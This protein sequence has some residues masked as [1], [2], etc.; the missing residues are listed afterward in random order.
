MTDWQADNLDDE[1][2]AQG[3]TSGNPTL[4]RYDRGGDIGG[5]IVRDKLWFYTSAR[6]RR[7]IQNVLE[8]FRPDGE[9]CDDYE[10]GKFMWTYCR[11]APS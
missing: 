5:K 10:R 6:M 9:P 1:L 3:V 2:V 7:N 8:C 11:N 4:T